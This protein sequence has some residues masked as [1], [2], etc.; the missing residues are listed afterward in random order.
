MLASQRQNAHVIVTK[1]DQ[2]HR[3]DYVLNCKCGFQSHGYKNEDKSIGEEHEL[4]VQAARQ[5]LVN[6]HSVKAS[7]TPGLVEVLPTTHVG[8]L[9]Y[10][11]LSVLL[12]QL[13][14]KQAEEVAVAKAKAAP[15]IQTG[16]VKK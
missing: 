6:R 1:L 2:P 10:D 12:S 13:K 8:G 15:A 14:A 3:F 4:A 16:G 9:A 11:Q 5:H 7:E